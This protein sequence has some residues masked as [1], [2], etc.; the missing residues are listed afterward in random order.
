MPYTVQ[1]VG[2]VCF[3]RERG[4][5]RALLPDGRNP[6]GGID[7]HYGSIVVAPGSIQKIEGWNG[8]EG[9]NAGTFPLEPCEIVIQEADTPGLL[10]TSSHDGLLPQLRQIDPNFEIDPARAQTIAKLR[11][12]QGKLTVRSVPGGT[13]LISQLDVPHDGPI[14]IVVRPDDGSSERKITLAPGTE[15]AVAN[16]AHGNLYREARRRG[17][18]N[19]KGSHFKIYEKLSVNPVTLADQPN[20]APAPQSE[21]K[22]VLFRSRRAITLYTDCSNTGCC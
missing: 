11:V 19:G 2:L 18:T 14:D 7:P 12:R 4:G 16:M 13:A 17:R 21:S 6:D 10:D 1:F 22:H 5:R 20:V 3:F 9:I 8:V 15:I